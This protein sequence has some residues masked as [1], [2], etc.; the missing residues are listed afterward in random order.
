MLLLCSI[1]QVFITFNNFIA[2]NI[3]KLEPNLPGFI[4]FLLK[5]VKKLSLFKRSANN[6]GYQDKYI[7]QLLST[8]LVLKI[9]SSQILV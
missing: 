9:L 6:L 2:E 8:N 1:R 7:L 5:T 4:D 3:D